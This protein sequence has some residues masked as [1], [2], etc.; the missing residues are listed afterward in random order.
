[1]T[2]Q[3]LSYM[4]LSHEWFQYLVIALVL[5]SLK[6]QIRAVQNLPEGGD[7]E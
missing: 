6:K 2:I 4:F 1:M 7:Q 3:I 5:T